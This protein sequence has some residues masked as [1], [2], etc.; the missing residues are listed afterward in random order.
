MRLG[1]RRVVP[2][3]A[4]R[5]RQDLIEAAKV[6]VFVNAECPIPVILQQLGIQKATHAGHA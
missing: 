1:K 6:H 2:D 3:A 4:D 5:K